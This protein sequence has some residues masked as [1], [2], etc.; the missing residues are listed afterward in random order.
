MCANVKK[1]EAIALLLHNHIF[2]FIPRSFYRSFLHHHL[3]LPPDY[4]LS[5]VILFRPQLTREQVDRK[6]KRKRER[7]SALLLTRTSAVILCISIECG[8][9]DFSLPEAS[10]QTSLT[11][12][13]WCL[14]IPF[15]PFVPSHPHVLTQHQRFFPS[16]AQKAPD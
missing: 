1:T 6:K 13:P 9:C 16:R 7:K 4:F 5:C 15:F 14:E 11:K 8:G 3:P 12:V 2:F 10:S